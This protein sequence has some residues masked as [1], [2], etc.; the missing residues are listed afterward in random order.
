M[1]DNL[2]QRKNGNKNAKLIAEHTGFPN[3]AGS[4]TLAL[5]WPGKPTEFMSWNEKKKIILNVKE[6][7]RYYEAKEVDL[8]Y[9]NKIKELYKLMV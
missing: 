1:E 9:I 6:A 8:V 5:C 7:Y 4:E 3:F 2:P